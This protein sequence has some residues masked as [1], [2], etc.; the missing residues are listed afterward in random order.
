MRAAGFA[1]GCLLLLGSGPTGGDEA[2]DPAAD[3][4]RA[5]RL[6][7]ENRI[8]HAIAVYRKINERTGG[9][10]PEAR[11]GLARAYCRADEYEKAREQARAAIALEPPAPLLAEAYA[12]LAT[13]SAG[14]GPEADVLDEAEVAL[15]RALE[16]DE[17]RANPARYHVAS[18]LLRRGRES[19]GLQL[20]R[21]YV[22]REPFGELADRARAL[23]A[24]P[25]CAREECVPEFS[26]TSL[27]RETLRLSDF[28]GRVVVLEFWA[29]W[30]RPCVIAVPTLRKLHAR[31]KKEPVMWVGISSDRDV[32][33]L[34]RFVRENRVRWPQHWDRDSEFMHGSFGVTT[35]PTFVVIDHRGVERARIIG[36]NPR[37]RKQL[38]GVL[39]ETIEQAREAARSSPGAE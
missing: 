11:V 12:E 6:L 3:L 24:K 9:S 37:T 21:D 14:E 29:S 30:C 2:V 31:M 4:E 34:R 8:A 25:H 23:I 10:L 17:A 13:A 22:E 33:V 15:G 18:A 5:Q 27:D 20:L 16:L 28:T 26:L 38:D 35:L 39:E 19:Q 32:G 1:L 7:E 36:W